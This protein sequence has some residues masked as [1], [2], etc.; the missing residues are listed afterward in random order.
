MTINEDDYVVG[1]DPGISGAIAVVSGDGNFVC[2]RSMPIQAKKSGRNEVDASELYTFF[3]KLPKGGFIYSLVERVSAM[4][5][6]GV[7]G[8]FSLGD[9][10]GCVRA[11][12]TATSHR[13]DYVAAA[14]WKKK[15]GLNKNKEYSRTLAR[16]MFP[17]AEGDLSRK[18]DE[19]RAEALLLARFASQHH[20]W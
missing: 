19:G 11:I 8:M 3:E 10:F 5:G 20:C 14:V 16:K 13:T 4:P 1:I 15:M 12:A 7:S 9:S 18:K 2:V 17:T 6:Q